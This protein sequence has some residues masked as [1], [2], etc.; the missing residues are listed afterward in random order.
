M[1][2]TSCRHV[3]ELGCTARQLVVVIAILGHA[4]SKQAV[5]IRARRIK[6]VKLGARLSAVASIATRGKSWKQRHKRSTS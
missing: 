3:A 5:V 4:M 2:S 6:L 1:T